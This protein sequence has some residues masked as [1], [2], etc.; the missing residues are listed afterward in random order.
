MNTKDIGTVLFG[1]VSLI[2]IVGL[3]MAIPTWLLWNYCLVGAIDGVNQIGFLQALGINI[4]AG[5]LFKTTISK[6]D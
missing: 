3:I 5:I 6:K 4:L 2:V 1:M